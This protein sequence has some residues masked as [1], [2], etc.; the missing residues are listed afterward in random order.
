[1]TIIV[2]MGRKKKDKSLKTTNDQ[3]SQAKDTNQALAPQ[4]PPLT[5]ENNIS[6]DV[7]IVVKKLS[8][9]EGKVKRKLEK[10]L[11]MRNNDGI[12]NL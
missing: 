11:E 4:N 3:T 12:R 9:G 2:I 10:I 8:I 5:Q 7:T 1:M 6:T